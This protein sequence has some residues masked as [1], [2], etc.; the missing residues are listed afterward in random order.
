MT[1]YSNLVVALIAVTALVVA[2]GGH[3]G[4]PQVALAD[5]HE[6][7]ADVQHAIAICPVTTIADELMETERFQPERDAMQASLNEQLQPMREQL[8]TLQTELSD[9]DPTAE[10][11]NQKRQQFF[12]LQQQFEQTRGAAMAKME[13]FVTEQY[14][15]AYTLVRSSAAAIA[16]EQGFDYVLASITPDTEVMEGTM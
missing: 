13:T 4:S 2:L 5:D 8:I 9:A 6:T 15:Q 3:F 7:A 16:E 1:R 11:T 10:D 14:R 12:M